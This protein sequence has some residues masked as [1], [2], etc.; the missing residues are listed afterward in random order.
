MDS[1]TRARKY[2]DALKARQ[3]KS[4]KT[5]TRFGDVGRNIDAESEKP[6]L[7][8]HS[9]VREPKTV[10]EQRNLESV[11]VR[12]DLSKIEEDEEKETDVKDFVKKESKPIVRPAPA[13]TIGEQVE[14]YTSGGA[15]IKAWT[16]SDHVTVPEVIEPKRSSFFPNFISATI[17]IQAIEHCLSGVDEL[18]W[19]SPNYFSL[20]ARIYWCVL[21]YIQIMKAK[22]TA[23]KLSKAESTWFRAFRRIY[24]LE[25]L[26]VAGPLVPFYANITAVK[27]NDDMYDFI[28]P[29]YPINQGLEVEKGAPKINDVFYLL[30]NIMLLCEFM[31]LFTTLTIARLDENVNG[32]G[33]RFFDDLGNFIPNR[34]GVDFT[35]AGI[36][37]PATLTP[38]ASSILATL[39]LDKPLPESKDRL[40]EILGYWKRSKAADIPGT[41]VT[42][43]FSNIGT[44]M[45]MIDDFEW[46]EDCVEMAT[47]QC[48]F[49]R[50]S[51]NMSQIPSTGGSEVLICAHITGKHPTYRASPTW[52]PRNWRNLKSQFR[53]T[54]ADTT[55][56]QIFNAAYALTTATISW[57]GNNHPVGGRQLEHR[58][59][60]YWKNKEFQ[61]AQPNDIEVQRRTL[62]MIRSL[63]FVAHGDATL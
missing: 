6:R 51:I 1:R 11:K 20:P 13:E 50:N 36:T 21:F 43:D 27:P 24:P 39:G 47:T 22:E 33:A 5:K 32:A 53:T 10:E 7:R 54:R 49:F 42:E 3:T 59:G 62:T 15:F 16:I 38:A 63:F 30:P 55:Y 18:K 14:K 26:P 48:K 19:I 9:F 23:K 37:F 8:E 41:G 44:S 40:K 4:G 34:T 45:R 2:D 29:D 52:F 25:S 57:T 61:F 12:E 60:P 31:K 17:I 35:F 46:F 28:Y 58:K 56:E